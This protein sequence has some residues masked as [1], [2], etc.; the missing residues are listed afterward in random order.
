MNQIKGPAVFLAQFYRDQKPYNSIESISK[1]CASLGYRGV[2]IPTWEKGLIDIDAAAGSQAYCDDY[3][4]K[5]KEAGVEAVDLGSY[6][7]G[8]C[9]AFHPAYKIGFQP[10]F[11][12]G[13][14]EAERLQWAE[15]QLKKSIMAA[16]RMGIKNVS[17]MSGGLLWHMIYPWPQ[18]PDGLVDEAFSELAARWLPV[19]R[20]A[21]EKGVTIGYELHPGS[22]LYD[23]ATFEL[24]LE[25]TG[26]IS[27]ACITY[28]PSH[29]LLQ[30]LDY[31]DFIRLYADRITAMH[32][33]DAEFNPTGRCGVYGGY[34]GWA[35][36]AGRFRSLGD[37]QID[38]KRIFS[39]L[40]QAG[41]DG[42]AIL[43]W[44]CCIKSPEQGAREG[45]PFIADHIIEVSDV[46]FDDFAGGSTDRTRNRRMLGL[47]D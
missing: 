47:K 33:K 7:Q 46:A 25:K 36:R 3:T 21:E 29:F 38:F 26:G 32:V 39:M 24:F 41:Y 23:G 31:V 5:L 6:L 35:D 45:A 12:S 17:V 42:W 22:D 16:S 40:T 14:G 11:P 2:Q 43:E 4:G 27:S 15:E 20:Y 44:E 8:Q 28:D 19:L 18:R 10:F 13:L 1:W 37:G 9:M 30:Q 34:Q